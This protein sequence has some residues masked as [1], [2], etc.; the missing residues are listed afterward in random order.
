[1]WEFQSFL[2]SVVNAQN[3]F[4][5]GDFKVE[6]IDFYQHVQIFEHFHWLLI[7]QWNV[8]D[9]GDFSISRCQVRY[10]QFEDC[11]STFMK[12][13]VSKGIG[14]PF[15]CVDC[16]LKFSLVDE[17]GMKLSF[18]AS[19][20]LPQ[21]ESWAL[22]LPTIVMSPKKFV[23]IASFAPCCSILPKMNWQDLETVFKFSANLFTVCTSC[24]SS[25]AM[26]RKSVFRFVNSPCSC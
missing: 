15:Q 4:R 25:W 21:A 5:C 22:R 23:N 7:H 14:F 2:A 24:S 8:H 26:W 11:V 1:V 19:S 12:Q 20:P 10:Q 13:L 16:L 6:V 18:K 17:W 9:D 3:L